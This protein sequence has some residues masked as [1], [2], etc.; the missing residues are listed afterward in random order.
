MIK[1]RRVTGGRLEG[2]PS[3]I[4]INDYGTNMSL[5]GMEGRIGIKVV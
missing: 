2:A 4:L 3:N 5:E 1:T